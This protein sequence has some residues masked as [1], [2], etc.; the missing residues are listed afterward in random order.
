MNIKNKIP[1]YAVLNFSS[2]IVYTTEK[3]IFDITIL[4]RIHFILINVRRGHS[5]SAFNI[6]CVHTH[7]I[8]SICLCIRFSVY[9]RI[10]GV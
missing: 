10:Y 1:A 9:Y 2:K 6:W 7:M 8:K 3:Q 5:C 4:M